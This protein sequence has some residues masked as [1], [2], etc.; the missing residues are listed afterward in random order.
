MQ[1]Y[2]VKAGDSLYAIARRFQT[3]LEEAVFRYPVKSL[4]GTPKA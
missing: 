1:I 4:Q 3:T 2:I